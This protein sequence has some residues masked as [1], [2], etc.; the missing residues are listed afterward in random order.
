[1][2]G[3]AGLVF[4]AS[5]TSVAA[6]SSANAGIELS[7]LPATTAALTAQDT[8]FLETNLVATSG[9][10]LGIFVTNKDGYGHS[11]DVDQLGVHV[12]LPANSTTFIAVRP[13]TSGSLEFYCAVPGHRDAGMVGTIAVK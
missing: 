9:E 7:Q 11:F 6:A 3:V 10:V 12:A 13:T 5:L 2:A 1:V 8:K 4:G